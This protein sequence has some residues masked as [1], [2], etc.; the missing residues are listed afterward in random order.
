[1]YA[2]MPCIEVGWSAK[3]GTSPST[4]SSAAFCR[5]AHPAS[6][7]H[8]SRGHTQTCSQP[9]V[10]QSAVLHPD[11]SRTPSPLMNGV[12]TLSALELHIF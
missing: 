11:G 2:G 10:P 5:L 7:S 6:L 3:V 4:T 9:T 1:M 8:L 12:L